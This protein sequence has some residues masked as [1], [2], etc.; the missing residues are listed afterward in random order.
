MEQLPTLAQLGQA[1]KLHMS[2]H[3]LSTRDL[4]RDTGISKAT[5]SRASRGYDMRAS[6][7][8]ELVKKIWHGP[9]F[10]VDRSA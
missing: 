3:K 9:L 8:I 10:S 6:H 4:E 5:L 2:V 1:I 7:Y